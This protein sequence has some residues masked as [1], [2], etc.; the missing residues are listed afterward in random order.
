LKRAVVRNELQQCGQDVR[1]PSN[2]IPVIS[3]EVTSTM[4][5][6]APPIG[7][8]HAASNIKLPSRNMKKTPQMTT[9]SDAQNCCVFALPCMPE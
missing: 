4:V 3:T 5:L 8:S 6:S 1:A 7:G 9:V 2:S